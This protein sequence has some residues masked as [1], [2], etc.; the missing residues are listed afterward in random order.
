MKINEIF[1]NFT[2]IQFQTHTKNEFLTVKPAN[3]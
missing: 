1:V 2:L 3:F